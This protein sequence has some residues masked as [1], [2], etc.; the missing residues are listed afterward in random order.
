MVTA[1]NNILIIELGKENNDYVAIS[2][3]LDLDKLKI[4]RL[5]ERKD[6]SLIEMVI[7]KQGLIFDS[8]NK[9]V[10]KFANEDMADEF[11]HYLFNYKSNIVGMMSK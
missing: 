6:R 5:E 8:K 10:V 1:D 11:L 4:E 7:T 2:D 9:T 3:V